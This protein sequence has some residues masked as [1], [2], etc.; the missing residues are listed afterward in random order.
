MDGDRS[1]E[2]AVESQWQVVKEEIDEMVEAYN[3]GDIDA[4]TE[5][6]ADVIVVIKVICAMMEID[7]SKAYRAKMMY[8]LRKSGTTNEDGKV[9]DDSDISKPDFGLY[10]NGDVGWGN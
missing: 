4:F 1:R 6:Q 5:E 8:N 7:S 3:E 9:I 2:D 10:N